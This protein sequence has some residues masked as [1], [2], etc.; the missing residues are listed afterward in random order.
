MTADAKRFH[1]ETDVEGFEGD[2]RVFGKRLR[3][4]V[5]RDLT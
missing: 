1:L 3:S 5:P 2:V 4:A